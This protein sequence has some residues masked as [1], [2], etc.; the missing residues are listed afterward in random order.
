[1]IRFL[2]VY[3]SLIRRINQECG[4]IDAD[5][6]K[7][8][9]EWS[10]GRIRE[11]IVQLFEICDP[12]L[13]DNT[14]QGIGWGNAPIVDQFVNEHVA[15]ECCSEYYASRYDTLL[16][17]AQLCRDV[18]PLPLLHATAS[19]WSV[20]QDT[21]R[22]SWELSC[23]LHVLKERLTAV[24]DRTGD[25]RRGRFMLRLLDLG[26]ENAR[27]TGQSLETVPGRAVVPLAV[28]LFDNL[29]FL[30]K[31]E[32]ADGQGYYYA[33]TTL[34]L[35][36]PIGFADVAQSVLACTVEQ[37]AQLLAIHNEFEAMWSAALRDRAANFKRNRAVLDFPFYGWSAVLSVEK[38]L[39][40]AQ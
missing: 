34:N 1:M 33:L 19:L 18:C 25:D 23:V 12:V 37:D 8:S 31:R 22:G 3:P 28:M 15:E 20:D 17:D 9:L 10:Y 21:S 32:T 30:V 26:T 24:L 14:A 6:L 40:I 35:K 39:F 16:S 4:D 11:E 29:A 7:Q 2:L 36:Q 38:A 13:R 5:E 27:S